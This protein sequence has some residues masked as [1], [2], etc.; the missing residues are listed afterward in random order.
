VRSRRRR[1]A[2]SASA[3]TEFCLGHA[4]LHACCRTDLRHC[5]STAMH[6][7]ACMLS[8]GQPSALHHPVAWALCAHAR[9][10]ARRVWLRAHAH[11]RACRTSARAYATPSH[12]LIRQC[13]HTDIP[14]AYALRCAPRADGSQNGR[15]TACRRSSSRGPHSIASCC[16]GGGGSSSCIRGLCGPRPARPPHRRG[17]GK[18][19][20][21]VPRASAHIGGCVGWVAHD[22]GCSRALVAW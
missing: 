10:L 14:T 8:I 12:L 11:W 21:Q 3:E 18:N 19:G 5:V 17:H 20:E 4:V 6:V 13:L 9:M 22:N 15:R 1:H 2:H 7:C 16:C